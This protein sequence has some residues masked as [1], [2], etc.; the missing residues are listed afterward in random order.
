MP[1]ASVPKAASVWRSSPCGSMG[2]DGGLSF[3]T[4]LGFMLGACCFFALP[5]L[6]VSRCARGPER[7]GRRVKH[8]QTHQLGRD[9]RYCAIHQEPKE[10]I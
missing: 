4:H 1:A 8:N 9:Q 6:A 2:T 3:R 5:I 7:G 10:N